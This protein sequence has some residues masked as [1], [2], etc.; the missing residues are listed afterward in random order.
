MDYIVEDFIKV[1]C[2]IDIPTIV[3]VKLK[4][5]GLGSY[6]NLKP[7][8]KEYLIEIETIIQKTE[9]L[10]NEYMNKYKK[11]KL[12][13]S[14]IANKIGM[15]RQTIYNNRDILELY[16]N[17]SQGIQ[18]KQDLII[19]NG[20][21]RKRIDELNK[22]ISNLQLRDVK[23]E[24]LKMDYEKLL[25]ERDDAYKQVENL[26]NQIGDLYKRIEYLERLNKDKKVS[27]INKK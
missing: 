9:I 18:E 24:I 11:N 15:S 17:K 23:I 22:D 10:R 25:R 2:S 27:S 3:K 4:D 20:E 13:V 1:E 6:D 8:I 21:L 19:E 16:I 26:D 7:N 14:F 12:S 5:F